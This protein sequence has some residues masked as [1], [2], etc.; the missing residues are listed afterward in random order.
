M[1]DNKHDRLIKSW[2]TEEQI[3]GLCPNGIMPLEEFRQWA[4]TTVD[5]DEMEVE[6]NP[7]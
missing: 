2:S 5:E 3:E 4:L 1:P 6:S 7:E